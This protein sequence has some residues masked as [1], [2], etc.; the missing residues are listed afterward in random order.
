MLENF[1]AVP[2]YF[3]DSPDQERV[4]INQQIQTSYLDKVKKET[5]SF[6]T[7]NT[8]IQNVID[9]FSLTHMDKH[10]R[11]HSMIYADKCGWTYSQMFVGRSWL[12]QRTH[13]KAFDTMIDAMIG[14]YGVGW[15]QIRGIY[16]VD[17]E[18]GE[19]GKLTFTHPQEPKGQNT[20]PFGNVY[21]SKVQYEVKAGRLIL[22]PS[23]MDYYYAPFTAETYSR[24]SINFNITMR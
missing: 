14:G 19:D 22:F 9:Y 8:S 6:T 21:H 5:R 11:D 7:F 3:Y 18:S 4:K 10:A 20:F 1:F 12:E 15:D 23:W 24:I 17:G 2:I 16:F 13:I